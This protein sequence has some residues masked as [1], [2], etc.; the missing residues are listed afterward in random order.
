VI[1][2]GSALVTGSSSKMVTLQLPSA[3]ELFLTLTDYNFTSPF[4]S[5]SM[6]LMS[7]QSMVSQLALPGSVM[8]SDTTGPMTLY[9]DV[10]WAAQGVLD[11]GLY[12]VTATFL[13]AVAA[14]PLPESGLLLVCC[15]GVA[16]LLNFLF[17]RRRGSVRDRIQGEPALP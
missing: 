1:Y 15:L 4:A 3:G 2:S 6:G 16:L 13:P 12:N 8:Y 10:S 5:L 11:A 17:Q 7:G 14:V 9:A